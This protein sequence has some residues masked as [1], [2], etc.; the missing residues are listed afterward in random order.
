MATAIVDPAEENS[1]VNIN[2]PTIF[3]TD[4]TPAPPLT[5]DSVNRSLSKMFQDWQKEQLVRFTA[6]MACH[7]LYPNRNK[8]ELLEPTQELEGYCAYFFDAVISNA[9]VMDPAEMST[10]ANLMVGDPELKA[11]P[12][13]K[14]A[15]N[16]AEKAA[17]TS[18]PSPAVV[19]VVLKYLQN[20]VEAPR[21][22]IKEQGVRMVLPR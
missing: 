18:T 6:K 19:I 7:L 12:A 1:G 11:Y 5:D 8:P 3:V 14:A 17:G 4:L 16:D 20:A 2:T 15:V 10:L 9:I 13:L 21:I 22:G